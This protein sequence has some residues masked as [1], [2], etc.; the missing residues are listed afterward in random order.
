MNRSVSTMFQVPAPDLLRPLPGDDGEDS[1]GKAAQLHLRAVCNGERFSRL[2]RHQPLHDVLRQ[3][4]RQPYRYELSQRLACQ[5]FMYGYSFQHAL[6]LNRD[7][8]KT[9]SS[10]DVYLFFCVSLT[11]WTDHLF[12]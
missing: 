6:L 5:N 8:T 7:K 3:Q 2:H 1:D 4:L 12:R 9:I 10:F 11:H